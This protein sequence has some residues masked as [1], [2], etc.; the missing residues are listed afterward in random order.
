MPL[1]SIVPPIRISSP[2][3]VQP[4]WTSVSRIACW[5]T[6]VGTNHE[7]VA[8]AGLDR[9][10]DAEPRRSRP[11]VQDP[12]ATST[13]SASRSPAAVPDPG[14]AGAIGDEIDHLGGLDHL[15]P[16]RASGCRDSRG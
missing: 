2:N 7:A 16:E 15:D 4:T 12:A 14:E 10:V 8:L 1:N 13:S 3:G 5:G 6:T 11:D 9:E